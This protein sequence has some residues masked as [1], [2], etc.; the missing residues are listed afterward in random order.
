MSGGYGA[1]AIGGFKP[2]SGGGGSGA[3]S[4]VS[5]TTSGLQYY[6]NFKNYPDQALP[7]AANG[8]TGPD[9][10]YV[11]NTND[12][13]SW[14][15]VN[16][17]LIPTTN[18]NMDRCRRDSATWLNKI[19]EYGFRHLSNFH[20]GG[21]QAVGASED[22]DQLIR[23]QEWQR[24]YGAASTYGQNISTSTSV[25]VLMN[26]YSRYKMR[27][28]WTGAARLLSDWQNRK[29]VFNAFSSG[30]G[31]TTAGGIGVI[32]YQAQYV[33]GMTDYA[34][35]DDTVISVAGL[36]GTDGFRLYD[37]LG[38]LVGSS[39]AQSS[40]T[41]TLDTAPNGSNALCDF[42]FYGYLILFTDQGTWATKKTAG[43]YPAQA[44]E[45]IWGGN[46]YTYV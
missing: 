7:N 35:Y 42:P 30:A 19:Y 8:S 32:A 44:G 5:L 43:Q 38:N 18:G 37:A 10:W 39:S 4:R 15:L 31:P 26:T 2:A 20:I 16:G 33:A 13:G 46:L 41:A 29:S 11:H 12:Q 27:L 24:D 22:Y 14:E 21:R 6:I 9:G 3:S 1:N 17:L 25:R 34:V 23:H 40:G 36:S 28:N 45:A